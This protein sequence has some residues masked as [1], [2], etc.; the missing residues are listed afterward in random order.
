VITEPIL[1]WRV[2]RVD[3][4]GLLSAVVWGARW[5]PRERFEAQ[6]E[7]RAFPFW[8]GTAPPHGAPWAGCARGIYAFKHRAQAALLAREKVDGAPLALGR[9]SLWGKV[10]ETERGYRAALAYPYDL[11]LLGGSEVL[12]AQVRSLY[13]VDVSTAPA[14]V[15]LHRGGG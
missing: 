6:C 9:A 15:R 5:E 8:V 1:G 14:A 2:W 3:D 4:D 13:A 12:A 10:L 11:E 7:D